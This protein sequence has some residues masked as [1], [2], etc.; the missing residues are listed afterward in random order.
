MI[1]VLLTFVLKRTKITATNSLQLHFGYV[2]P[3][4]FQVVIKISN[5]N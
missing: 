2:V 3:A 5:K 4:L 1:K